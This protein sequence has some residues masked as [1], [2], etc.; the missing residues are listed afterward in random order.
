MKSYIFILLNFFL[1]VLC[2]AQ[3]KND[4]FGRIILNTFI[5]EK[6]ALPEEA[7]NALKNKLNQIVTS[8]GLGGSQINPR[9]IITADVIIGSKDIIP[10]PPQM[11]AQQIEVTFF[12]GDALK[13]IRFANATLKLKGVGVN[14]NKSFIEAIKNI[15]TNNALIDTFITEG[16]NKI[17]NYYFEQ[18]DFILKDA[19]ALAKQGKYDTA[20]YELCMVPEVCKECYMR[21]LDSMQRI[22]QNKIDNDCKN[23][24]YKAK[25]IWAIEQNKQGAEKAGEVITAISPF[26][27]CRVEV[28][29]LISEIT[30]KIK[31]DDRKKWLLQ[32]KR[33]EDS[34]S[35]LREKIKI[36][37]ETAKRTDLN[38]E[39]Q[40]ERN[41]ELDK[42]KINAYREVALEQLR[43]QP[44]TIT[45]NRIYWR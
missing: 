6:L 18:C 7:K 32:I 25:T 17:I 19:E 22:Y 1:G 27:S 33:Y 24:L 5:P 2:N 45:Y 23:K 4:D 11:I 43:N 14:E 16:K 39:K 44:R 8:K 26:S 29:N 30:D 35:L 10:G 13:N 36:A 21:C 15:N 38:S 41:Y 3:I 40:T 9:F 28:A 37:E 42:L 34:V 31:E 12:I 20:I